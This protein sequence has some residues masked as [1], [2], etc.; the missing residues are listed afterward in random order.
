[1]QAVLDNKDQ[2]GR[3]RFK[4]IDIEFGFFI[5][6]GLICAFA[7]GISVALRDMQKKSA[8]LED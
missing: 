2:I 1:V 8:I 4:T 5:C 7:C 6:I 3:E